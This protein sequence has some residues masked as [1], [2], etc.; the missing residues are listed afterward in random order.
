MKILPINNINTQ[1][2]QFKAK[3]QKQDIKELLREVEDSDIDIIPKL[4]TM[5]DIINK[6]PGKNA[7]IEHIGLWHHISI[8]GK[9]ICQKKTY[10]CTY[11]ALQDATVKQK[12]TLIKE[13][14]IRR[15]SEEDFE[16]EFYKNSKKDY[17]I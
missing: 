9:S 2:T 12:N 6:H 7:K 16:N 13:S 8:D 3:F 10:L 1:Q 15:L 4:Y 14:P 11:H 17:V 5:L